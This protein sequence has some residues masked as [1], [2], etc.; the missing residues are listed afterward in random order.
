M[1]SYCEKKQRAAVQTL[2]MGKPADISQENFASAR[3]RCAAE[4][5]NDFSMRAYCEQKQY[6]GIRELKR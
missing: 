4:W 2:A 1:R 6:V 3:R 5:P